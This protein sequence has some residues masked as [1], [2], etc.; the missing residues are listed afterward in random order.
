MIRRWR[1]SPEWKLFGVLPKASPALAVAWWS[2]IILRGVLPAVFAVAMGLLIGAV[3]RGDSLTLPLM[4]AGA[5][6]IA[7][8]VLSPIHLAV[9]ANLGGRTAAWLYDRLTWACVTPPGI[10]HL[11]RPEL[12]DDLTMARD[13]DLGISG[14]PLHVSMDFIAAGL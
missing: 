3:R 1:A 9:S 6:F 11:E 2:I 10:G 8:Q 7:L 12:I 4:V 13:F 14:P 5:V